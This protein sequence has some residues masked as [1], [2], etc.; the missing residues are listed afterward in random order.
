MS[1]AHILP[2]DIGAAGAYEAY[3]MWKY[4][5]TPL[6]ETLGGVPE[7]EREALIGMAIG[8]GQQTVT[9]INHFAVI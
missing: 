3:R 4:H 5:Y 8:E 7:R 1:L 9:R 6:F 2:A